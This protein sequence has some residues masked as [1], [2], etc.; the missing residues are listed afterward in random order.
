MGAESRHE[1]V[2]VAALHELALLV[3]V[4]AHVWHRGGSVLS[5][6][7]HVVPCL[8]ITSGGVRCHC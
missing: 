4:S 3:A 6:V 7:S 1:R 5:L 8:Q 2:A